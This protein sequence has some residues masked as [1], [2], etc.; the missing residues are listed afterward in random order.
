MGP[1]THMTDVLKR[2]ENLGMDEPLYAN[3]QRAGQRRGERVWQ[4][5]EEST[6][7]TPWPFLDLVFFNYKAGVV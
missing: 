2:G 3:E 7:P 1:E 6:L 5:D 4:P